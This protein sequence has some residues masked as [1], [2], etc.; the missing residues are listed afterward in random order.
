MSIYLH[1]ATSSYHPFIDIVFLDPPLYV[2]GYCSWATEFTM[3]PGVENVRLWTVIRAGDRLLLLCNGE[4]IFDQ[5][6]ELKYGPDC[7]KKWD[8][9]FEYIYFDHESSDQP[10]PDYYREFKT[11]KQNSEYQAIF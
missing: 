5:M 9:N 4:L 1:D 3:P 8:R 7:P 10:A 6:T 2:V 11:G